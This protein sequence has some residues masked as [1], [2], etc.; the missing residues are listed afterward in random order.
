MKLPNDIKQL[1]VLSNNEYIGL[2][3]R[4][5][6]YNYQPN[7]INTPPSITMNRG[8]LEPFNHGVLHPIFA[9]NLPE[10]SNR[11]YIA[12]KLA[13]YAN[14]DDMYLLA[15]QADNGIGL[16]SYEGDIVLPEVEH[17]PIS[18]II[19]YAGESPIF[20]SLLERYYLRNMVGG[21]QPKVL[22][23]SDFGRM[24]EQKNFIVKSSSEEF[25]LLTINEYVCMQAAR[26]CNLNAPPTYLSANTELF[27]IERFDKPNGTPLGYEDFTTLMKKGLE[28]TAKYQGSY[29]HLL[30]ATQ[31]F[32]KNIDET[33][34]M[35]EYIIF[36]CL[37]GNGDAHLKNFALQYTP[38]YKHVFVSPIFDVT[39]T[40]IYAKQGVIDSK[41]ALKM[42]NSKTFPGRERLLSLAAAANIG[43]DIANNIIDRLAQG[44]ID[45]ISSSDEVKIFKGLFE[46]ISESVTLATG[47]Q[48]NPKGYVYDRRLKFE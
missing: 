47:T 8:N 43:N 29:E 4:T 5:A 24:V 6:H 39:H 25:P 37:I 38:N 48:Y 31:I 23:S 32:T 27:V 16:L 1:K 18:E 7:T 40:Q 17:T 10:G 41:M 3:T 46:S 35:Y 21:M 36:N 30:K 42:S 19:N 22:L 14:V 2:L 12:D 9:Q 33:K 11:R 45:Y 34:K 44:I 28:P 20:P 26:A 13:R 15:L